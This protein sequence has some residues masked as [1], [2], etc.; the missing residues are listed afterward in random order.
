MGLK[1]IP[2]YVIIKIL[3]ALRSINEE[4]VF[5]IYRI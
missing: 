4:K 2:I 3:N 1:L 5:C